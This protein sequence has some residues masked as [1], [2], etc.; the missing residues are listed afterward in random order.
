MELGEFEVLVKQART[1]LRI[2]LLYDVHVRD[3]VIE[4]FSKCASKF[5]EDTLIENLK[6]EFE[7][8]C[9]EAAAK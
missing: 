3:A 8:Y 2:A 4:P 5:E 9:K 1:G 7:N 6:E